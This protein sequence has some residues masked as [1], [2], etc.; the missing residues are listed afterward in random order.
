MGKCL[1]MWQTL[2]QKTSTH[3][4]VDEE[5]HHQVMLDEIVDHKSGKLAVLPD[6]GC[7]T[8]KG[9]RHRRI[10]T[11]GWR[12]ALQVGSRPI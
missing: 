1:S 4:Q 3:T 2:L 8:L 5:G 10:T 9:R 7:T 12:V 6:D 11:K